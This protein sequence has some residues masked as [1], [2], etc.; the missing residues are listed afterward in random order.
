LNLGHA[1]LIELKCSEACEDK[2]GQGV[3]GST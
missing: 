3:N 2:N 1:E